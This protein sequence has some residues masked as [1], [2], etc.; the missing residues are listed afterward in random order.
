MTTSPSQE[1][2]LG[3]HV[4]YEKAGLILD[5]LP[6]P[7]NADA[8]IVEANIKIAA[9][10]NLDKRDFVLQPSDGAAPAMAEVITRDQAR[11]HARIFF[12]IPT[13]NRDT[14]AT[15]RWR[16]HSLGEIA[17]PIQTAADF[18]KGCSLRHAS[19]HA[20]VLDS[21]VACRTIVQGQCKSL[22]ASAVIVGS[23][24][25][26]PLADYELTVRTSTLK[27][28]TLVTQVAVTRAQLRA[29]ET[30]VT[31]PLPKP[32]R[33]GEHLV[34]WQIDNQ[35]LHSDR[36]LVISKRRF[37]RSLRVSAT[38][39]VVKRET[40]GLQR[41]RWLPMRDGE[42]N[43]DGIMEVAPCFFV[44]SNENAVAGVV[45][46]HVGVTYAN[47]E[48]MSNVATIDGLVVTDGATPVMPVTL[49]AREIQKIKHLTLETDHGVIGTL[50]LVPAP[51]A[52]FNSEGGFAGSQEFQWS[53][54]AD[55]QLNEKL[56]QLLGGG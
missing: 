49:S 33:Q 52:Q 22:L 25:L 6:V 4:R 47:G 24:S 27:L 54:A 15:I 36:L 11:T 34:S 39:F 14:K 41:F 50:P 17:I 16:E 9:K 32:K 40:G 44:S 20:Q 30:L 35:L 7:T 10:V 1:T 5:A 48:S 43:L 45:R 23:G 55:E 12:R 38:R 31:V 13:P 3:L 42:P 21:A 19:L 29:K 56:D 18:L 51:T 46:L 37:L 26:A 53:A 28:P 8:V 2:P